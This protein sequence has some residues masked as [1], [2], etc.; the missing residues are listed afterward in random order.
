MIWHQLALDVPLERLFTYSHPQTLPLG[1]RVVVT[2][3]GKRKVGIVWEHISELDFDANKI[4]PIIEVLSDTPPLDEAWRQLV[5]FCSRYYLYPLGATAFT[6]LPQGLRNSEGIRLPEP[7]VWYRFNEVGKQQAPEPALAHHKKHA[8]WQAL[9]QQ[10]LSLGELKQLHP[11]A[12]TILA[13]YEEK[14]WLESSNVP[15]V[16]S[17][18]SELNLTSAQQH[19]CQQILACLNRFQAFLL[20]GITGSG[21]TEVY[22][23]VM[24]EVL[25]QG[26]QVLMLLPEINLTPQLLQRIAEKFIGHEP[27][28]LHSQTAVA[29]RSHDFVRAM[30][31][32]AK[33]IIG[34]RL[35]VLTPLPN[36][37]LIVV[38]E[39]HDSSF[40]QQ[41]ELRYHARDVALWR[42]KQ[43]NCPIVLGSAT[44]SLESWQNATTGR[45]Q[46]ISLT[47][48]ANEQ[49]SLPEV[50]IVDVRALPLEQGVCKPVKQTLIKNW[51]QGGM[52]LVYL[53]RRGFAPVLACTACGHTFDCPNCSA[54][55]VWHQRQ[56][57]LRCHHCDY[58]VAVPMFCPEC[59]NSDLTPL[60][61]GTQRV[62]EVLQEWM[63]HANIV[64]VD[65]DT[66]SGKQDW[67]NLYE[68]IQDDKIDVLVGTQMLAK[69]HDFARL[70]LV[71]VLNADGALYSSDFRAPEHL[72]AQLLQVSGRSGRAEKKGR[73]LIQTQLPDHPLFAALKQHDYIGFATQEL[74]L[75][76]LYQ[77]PPFSHVLAVRVDAPQ[78]QQAQE[79]LQNLM[80]DIDMPE[81]VSAFGPVPMLM[82]RLNG[83]ERAQVFV[84][85]PSRASLHKVGRLWQ[86]A[87]SAALPN[88]SSWRYSLDVD[89]QDA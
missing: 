1:T 33:L 89:V 42:A 3:R 30:T 36:L 32:E 60:G 52:S 20:H 74:A 24:A 43:A 58:R 47:E 82:A 48:R 78:M 39:E 28:V 44:P 62:E 65:R 29:A 75:R 22:F 37:G 71:V 70:N 66:T 80:A 86:A 27:A 83:R 10:Y 7:K 12:K 25:S 55:L 88:H 9:Q 72:F 5:A 18:S 73:V 77:F 16:Q 79:L 13:E 15:S 26:K 50:H 31:G 61:Q 51:Q 45:Y 68:Q 6:A 14:Q 87:L 11:Q 64:R 67:H 23:H 34:T 59:Q 56:R 21:K 46:L 69:G 19:T 85:S 2:F 49:A 35:S 38:D 81:D 53:N 41:N 40:K 57:Q 17:F 4:L 84:Q 76:E 63:P 54:K 8:L